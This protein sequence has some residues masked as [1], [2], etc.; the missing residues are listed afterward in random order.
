MTCSNQQWKTP[1]EHRRFEKQGCKQKQ[2]LQG[3][4]TAANQRTEITCMLSE[5][6]TLSHTITKPRGKTR[7]YFVRG[8][9]LCTQLY[10]E[11]STYCFN[12]TKIMQYN[13]I[14]TSKW[15]LRMAFTSTPIKNLL[16][17][18]FSILNSCCIIKWFSKTFYFQKT[19]V[20]ASSHNFY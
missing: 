13:D 8:E 11:N 1:F 18:K 10:V 15:C 16:Y 9:A 3:E 20:I 5:K 6:R 7:L 17:Y 12:F 14:Q 4:S 19:N 2:M